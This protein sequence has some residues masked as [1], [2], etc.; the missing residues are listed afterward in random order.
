LKIVRTSLVAVAL[1]LAATQVGF[2]TAAKAPAKTP[3][4][5]RVTIWPNLAITFYPNTFKRGTWDVVVNNRT[6]YRHQFSVAGIT[7][8]YI[9]AHKAAAAKKVK[10]KF[11]AT[12]TATLPDCGYPG[13]AEVPGATPAA[14]ARASCGLRPE[15]GP[16]GQVKVT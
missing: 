3:D 15:P 2:A 16:V 5:I 14:Q 9:P 1:A 7:W 4:H 13:S 8:D 6:R 10:F 12:Y 11:K